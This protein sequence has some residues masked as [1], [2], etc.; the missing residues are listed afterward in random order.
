MVEKAAKNFEMIQTPIEWEHIV[1]NATLACDTTVISMQ[2]QDFRDYTKF[3]HTAFTERRKD[4]QGMNFS[5]QKLHYLN[6]G[7]GETETGVTTHHPGTVWAR[8]TLHMGEI[9]I[10]IDLHKERQ[11][12][13]ITNCKCPSSRRMPTVT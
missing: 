7:V 8:Y 6:F 9:P 10:Q 4:T 3:L 2:R 12:R 11:A 1:E 5:F 13:N